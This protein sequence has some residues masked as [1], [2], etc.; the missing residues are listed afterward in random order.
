[1]YQ[2]EV[3]E[4]AVLMDFE[5]V[6]SIKNFNLQGLSNLKFIESL[7]CIEMM[8][9]PLSGD[10]NHDLTIIDLGPVVMI[11]RCN[12]AP[13]VEDVIVSQH[14]LAMQLPIANKDVITRFQE[15]PGGASH[16]PFQM[17]GARS[18]W[19]IPQN[20]PMLHLHVD[21]RLLLP[22]IGPQAKRDYQELCN[23]FSRK[24]YDGDALLQAAIAMEQAM[25][26][27]LEY[28]ER[29]QKIPESTLTGLLRDIFLPLIK[30]DLSEVKVSTRQKILS[31]SLDH[32]RENFKQPLRLADL[33]SASSTSVRNLQMVFK[34]ELGIS[35]NK[36]LQQFRLHRFRELLAA[37]ASVTEAA[38]SCGFKHLGRLTEQYAKVFDR[39]PSADLMVKSGPK[40]NV[41]SFFE[42]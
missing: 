30:S 9:T 29:Q 38:Y 36:Y 11:R 15:L 31:R 35:P 40:I 1:M 7:P 20:M 39:N 5:N 19:L 2:L 3:W 32:I 26:V 18:Q 34:Q 27:A 6:Y 8:S 33:A 24:A 12:H 14:T 42:Q 25:N 4:A 10:A 28:K 41:G 17:P 16:S 23:A 22:M 13:T 37:S 21:M